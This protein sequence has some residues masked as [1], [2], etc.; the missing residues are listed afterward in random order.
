MLVN[1]LVV[2]NIDLYFLQKVRLLFFRFQSFSKCHLFLKRTLLSIF[3]F[4][5]EHQLVHI[6]ISRYIY[7]ILKGVKLV[8]C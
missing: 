1:I 4:F 2:S 5:N 7:L 3:H 6:I 8:I